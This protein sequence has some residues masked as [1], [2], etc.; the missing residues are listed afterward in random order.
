MLLF[1]ILSYLGGYVSITVPEQC[2]EKFV[3]LAI[4]RGIFLW[5]ITGTG[6]SRVALKVRLNNVQPLRHVARMT[7][8]RFKITG[9]AGLPFLVGRLRRRKILP[10]GALVFI[11][12]LYILSSF[13]WFIEVTGNQGVETTAIERVARDAGLYRGVLKWSINQA[14]IEEKILRQVPGL[15]WVGVQVDGTR[16][17]IEVVEKVLP[18]EDHGGQPVDVVAIKDGLIKE[19]LVLSGH[20]LVEEG[21][22]V[23]A[24]QVLITAAM[25]PPVKT[26]DQATETQE[27]E[28]SENLTEGDE[29]IQYVRAR[30]LSGPGFGTKVME[31]CSW[32]KRVL[33]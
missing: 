14:Q 1:R 21:E 23:S 18:S 16:I 24:G 27:G 9:R 31:K 25:P 15:S 10:A 30:G 29:P 11:V 32:W 7:R 17:R 2:L 19:I 20:P 4:T 26:G 12:A 6:A 3:N 33:P 13:V 28:N 8:C 5:D 22:T